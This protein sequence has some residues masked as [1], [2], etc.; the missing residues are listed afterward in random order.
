MTLTSNGQLSNLRFRLSE[1]LSLDVSY[2]IMVSDD[3]N[4]R[5]DDSVV[6][7]EYNILPCVFN[8]NFN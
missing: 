2:D 1:A 6:N 4:H 5:T 3:L 8:S 7:N